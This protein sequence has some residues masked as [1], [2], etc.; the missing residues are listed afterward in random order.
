[1]SVDLST[2]YLGL[3]LRNPLVA[4]ASPLTGDLGVLRR[5]EE[6]GAAAVVLP[7]LFEEQLGF[8]RAAR[9]LKKMKCR[10]TGGS[11][12]SVRFDFTLAA[13]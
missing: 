5:M 7:S 8:L 11:R 3:N 9:L 12:S 13:I 2:T 1:M 10:P 4:A 6:A